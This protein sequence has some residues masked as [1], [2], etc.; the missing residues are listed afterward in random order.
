MAS[1]TI[2]TVSPVLTGDAV[3]TAAEAAT[4]DAATLPD[5]QAAAWQTFATLPDTATAADRVAALT[6]AWN[7]GADIT[8][9]AAVLDLMADLD[10]ATHIWR[11]SARVVEG[12]SRNGLTIPAIGQIVGLPG[13]AARNGEG[14]RITRMIR[15][16][17]LVLAAEASGKSATAI[18]P[19][20]VLGNVIQDGQM[21]DAIAALKSGKG[22]A[23]VTADITKGNAI[24]TKDTG[25]PRVGGTKGKGKGKDAPT[26]APT[27]G[28]AVGPDALAAVT[29]DTL[30]GM[31]DAGITALAVKV[32]R[33]LRGRTLADAEAADALAS[34][35]ADTV[36]HISPVEGE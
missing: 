19:F 24:G 25:T 9:E 1:K 15:A 12:F 35:L 33:A 13:A 20:V 3:L 23:A 22:A 4:A 29:A 6:A 2:S 30:A 34:V 28:V 14:K 31:T 36:A 16:W 27:G 32:C 26:D 8:A 11:H 7:V 18:R 5:R 21:T 10:R 17:R